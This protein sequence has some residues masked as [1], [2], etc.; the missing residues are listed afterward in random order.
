MQVGVAPWLTDRVGG[1]DDSA[2]RGRTRAHPIGSQSRL[3]NNSRVNLVAHDT[4]GARNK[5]R[6]APQFTPASEC[7]A[8]VARLDRAR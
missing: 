7:I 2:K 1:C 5:R 8:R 4:R 6:T 3:L